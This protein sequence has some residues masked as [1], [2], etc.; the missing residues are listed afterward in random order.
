MIAKVELTKICLQNYISAA[1]WT[2]SLIVTLHL[3]NTP[4]TED[5]TAAESYR[6]PR[7]TQ[8]YG[9]SVIVYLRDD[10]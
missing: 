1:E 8:T 2:V 10:R 5:V 7:E 6:L 3:D 9:A 4:D